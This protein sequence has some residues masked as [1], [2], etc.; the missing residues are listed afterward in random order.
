M[1]I[2]GYRG[3]VDEPARSRPILVSYR[4]LVLTIRNLITEPY[5]IQGMKDR[6]LDAEAKRLLEEVRADLA[7]A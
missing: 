2:G 7:V 6:D 4:S 1:L 5:K 3:S